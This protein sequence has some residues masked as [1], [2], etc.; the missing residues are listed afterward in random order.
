MTKR[1]IIFGLAGLAIGFIVAFTWTRSYNNNAMMAGSQPRSGGA[2]SAAP[3]GPASEQAGMASVRETIERAKNNPNDYDAQLEAAKLYNQI[4]RMNEVVPLIERAYKINNARAVG[5]YIPLV[6]GQYYSG[7]KD[8]ATAEKWFRAELD[9]K[10]K[11][12][13]TLIELGASFI[14]REPPVPDKAIDYLQSALKNNPNDAH[15]LVHLTQAYLQKKDAR[16]AEDSLSRAKQAD[17][18]N[19]MIPDLEKQVSALRSGQQVILPKE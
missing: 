3:A 5:D 11:D 19:K 6:L 18:S 17:P 9:A 4:G 13:D 15:A 10:P 8:Y 2:G 12:S 14:D 1:R 7:Q 16:A